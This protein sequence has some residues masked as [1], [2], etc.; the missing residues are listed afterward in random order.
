[1]DKSKK[2]SIDK[3]QVLAIR[4]KLELALQ[5]Q[6]DMPHIAE[7]YKRGDFMTEIVTNERIA[8]KYY[9][10][11][12]T[13]RGA[14]LY[15][16]RGYNA[17]LIPSFSGLIEDESLLEKL[18]WEHMSRHGKIA[19]ANKWGFSGLSEE[20]QK[21]MRLRIVANARKNKTGIYAMSKEERIRNA[22]IGAL[23]MGKKIMTEEEILYAISLYES[24]K[25]KRNSGY[26]I[27]GPNWRLISEKVNEKFHH[28]TA[29]RPM[30]S[31]RAYV[32]KKIKSEGM[33]TLRND[34]LWSEE[35]KRYVAEL[36]NSPE[37]QYREGSQQGH[38]DW[39]KLASEVNGKFRF[40]RTDRTHTSI[41]TYYYTSI[42]EYAM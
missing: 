24:P 36:A 23:K 2:R 4:R 26:G 3:V 11:E 34:C 9:V 29:D 12:K 25:Y 27:G 38:T 39:K 13:A 22:R 31:L 37:F 19:V 35:E 28:D 10:N 30:D 33:P 16:I 42:R 8:S 7:R 6:K 20:E 17:G 32:L 41:K 21:K 1:M 14:V 5:L 18:A 15:A 40:K